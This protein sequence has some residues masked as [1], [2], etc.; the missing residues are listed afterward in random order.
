MEFID[1]AG[2]E[3]WGLDGGFSVVFYKGREKVL[4]IIP[5]GP[6]ADCVCEAMEGRD[7]DI[8]QYFNLPL[9]FCWFRAPV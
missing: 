9:D 7:V 8:T 4:E 2:F 5:N 6:E 3:E 1:I